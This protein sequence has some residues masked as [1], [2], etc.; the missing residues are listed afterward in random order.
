MIW[1]ATAE[2][3]MFLLGRLS[4]HLKGDMPQHDHRGE[5]VEGK[6]ITSQSVVESSEGSEAKKCWAFSLFK[7]E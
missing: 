3:A 4:H 6:R 5:V 7:G 1:A 2:K